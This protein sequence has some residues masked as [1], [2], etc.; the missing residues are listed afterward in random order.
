MMPGEN[1]TDPALLAQMLAR[2]R[3][4]ESMMVEQQ[5]TDRRTVLAWAPI[6]CSCERRYV[7]GTPSWASCIVHGVFVVHPDGTTL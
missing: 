1:Y 2:A 6:L 3:E 5:M 4:I 7:P